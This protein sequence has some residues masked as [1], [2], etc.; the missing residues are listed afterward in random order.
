[1]FTESGEN[2]C[3]IREKLMQKRICIP[4]NNHGWLSKCNNPRISEA[5]ILIEKVHKKKTNRIFEN[6]AFSKM[7]G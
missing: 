6:E 2:R 5:R 7:R 3:I 1:V 4:R